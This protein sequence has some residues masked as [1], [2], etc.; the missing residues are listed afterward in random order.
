[1]PDTT[2]LPELHIDDTMPLS[3]V[4]VRHGQA[5]GYSI[6]RRD[7]PS[8]STLGHR[9]AMR[10]GKR[11]KDDLVDHIYVSELARARETAA[12]IAKLHPGVKVTVTN[13]LREVS[14]Y[15]FATGAPERRKS[16][17][18]A[19]TRERKTMQR[20]IEHL[21]ETH[22]P[23]QRVLLVCHGNIIRC[24]M[25]MFAKRNPRQSVL[26]DVNNTAVSIVEAW[27][28]GEAVVRLANCTRH[29]SVGQVT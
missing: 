5:E 12:P 2:P 22:K 9:Q 21:R 28:T 23:G 20:F 6:G 27:S 8:L 3:V 26:I 25:A 29:L 17:R 15:H 14:P 4:L 1:M 16:M 13:D 11:L 19:L 10:V 18:S 7:D 24:L